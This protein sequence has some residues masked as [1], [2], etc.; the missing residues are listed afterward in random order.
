MAKEEKQENLEDISD[1]EGMAKVPETPEPKPTTY[2]HTDHHRTYNR[3]KKTFDFYPE[4]KILIEYP[5]GYHPRREHSFAQILEIIADCPTFNVEGKLT[6]TA[7]STPK[8][9]EGRCYLIKRDYNSPSKLE[10][11]FEKLGRKIT[12]A[13]HKQKPLRLHV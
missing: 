6:I 4:I 7:K 2:F 5:I 12:R 13:Y 3:L 10:K 1:V 9:E 11:D 8:A